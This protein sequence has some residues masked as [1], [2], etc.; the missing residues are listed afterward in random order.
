MGFHLSRSLSQAMRSV[1]LL[2]AAAVLL[3]S[4]TAAT[5]LEHQSFEPPFEDIDSQ[6]MY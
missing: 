2:L 4:L 1:S 3:A 5:K 6:G